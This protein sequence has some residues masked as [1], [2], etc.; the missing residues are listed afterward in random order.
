MNHVE[1]KK[2]APSG[3]THFTTVYSELTN[4]TFVYYFFF[5]KGWVFSWDSFKRDWNR[6]VDLC[7]SK[8]LK[9]L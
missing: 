1:I 5:D 3:A 6:S 2:K 8:N 4:I 9:P 7:G